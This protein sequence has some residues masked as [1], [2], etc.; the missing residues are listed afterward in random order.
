MNEY[1]LAT[2][3]YNYFAVKIL[4]LSSSLA[5]KFGGAAFSESALCGELSKKNEVLVLS[6]TNRLDVRFAEAQGIKRVKGFKPF[7]VL[8]AYFNSKHWLVT[9]L[10]EAD[11][12][13]LNG[14]WFWEN[15][16]FAKLCK[17]YGT[18]YV[19]H[20]RGMLWVAYRR[21]RLKKCFNWL[22]GNW[23][24]QNASK[25]ILLSK[26]EKNH[27]KPYK[28]KNQDLCVVPNGISTPTP[29]VNNSIRE[30]Y[31]LY[32]GRVEPRKNLE[33]LIRA[34]ST[35]NQKDPTTVLRI[36]GPVEKNYDVPLT[37]LIEELKLQSCV[38]LEGPKYGAEKDSLMVGSVA[39]IYPAFEE[40]FGRTVFEAFASGT[41][42]LLPDLSGGAEYV[43]GFAPE[44]VYEGTSEIALAKK[45]AEILNLPNEK[46]MACISLSQE[47]ISKYLNWP[48]IAQQ[49]LDIYRQIL[50]CK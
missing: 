46:R 34:F 14:H 25:I 5:Q 31:F 38:F 19:L 11:V 36:V 17:K 40:S 30:K 48:L 23:I 45:M 20:P 22:I 24:V 26:Y 6:R 43:R 16:F 44:V 4:F 3:W 2:R 15:Y 49:V 21:P 7:E 27:C 32:L 37:K 1:S 8:L 18:P 50:V 42:C 47:W 10:I 33:F 13:H 28:V 39:V 29:T 35:L 12:F 9:D 41:I